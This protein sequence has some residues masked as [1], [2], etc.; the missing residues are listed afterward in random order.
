MTLV[1]SDIIFAEIASELGVEPA[2]VKAIAAVESSGAP[3]VA[4]NTT[5]P[6]GHDISG[7][8]VVQFEGHQFW[9]RLSKLRDP[10]LDPSRLLKDP[11]TAL[12]EDSTG[13]PIGPQLLGD[14]L[15]PALDMSKMRRV[16][17]EWD[18]LTAAR[19]IHKASA[20]ES[21]S[22]GAFQIM[23]FNW[24]ACGAGSLAE[25]VLTSYTLPGQVRLF[26]AFVKSDRKLLSALKRRD[27]RAFATIYNGV[28]GVKNGYDVKIRK[29]YEAASK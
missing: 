22:W 2:S 27:W 6:R 26:A 12:I 28:Q 3:L 15:Y 16:P 21:T 20:D 10:A 24:R 4:P 1:V 23:G 5:T 13:R 8:P 18:Q 9:R 19:A 14:I 25:F 17:E 29:A 7:Y 11:A